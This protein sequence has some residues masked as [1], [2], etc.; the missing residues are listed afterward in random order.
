MF[1][2]SKTW[3]IDPRLNADTFLISETEARAVLLLNDKRW[4]WI[5]IVP[6]VPEAEELHDLNPIRRGVEMDCAATI[7]NELKTLTGCEKINVATIGNIVRQLHIHI[8]ARST[9]DPNWPGPVWGFGERQT[10]SSAEGIALA[11]K[12]K[13]EFRATLFS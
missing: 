13:E 7:G 6:K 5:I 12:L 4:P 9:D 11:K 3:Q 10:Y 8:I 2:L 1:E